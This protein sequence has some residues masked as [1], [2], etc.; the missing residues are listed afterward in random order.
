MRCVASFLALLEDIVNDATQ[1]RSLAFSEN[2]WTQQD[3]QLSF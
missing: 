1:Q 3:A 2:L